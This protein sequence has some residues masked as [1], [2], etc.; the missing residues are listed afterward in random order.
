MIRRKAPLILM[1]SL[2]AAVC[3]M[4]GVS[5]AVAAGS[6]REDRWQFYIPLSYLSSEHIDGEGGS[7]VDLGSDI[8]WGFAFGYNFTERWMIGFEITWA[9]QD[10][11][12]RIVSPP[13]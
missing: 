8:G 12:A 1:L 4:S 2:F 7:F 11:S 10:Y 3:L 9:Q 6:D 5:P 13:S